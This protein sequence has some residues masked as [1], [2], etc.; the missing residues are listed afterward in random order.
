M[1]EN[2]KIL[3]LV[4]SYSIGVTINQVLAE[5]E[6]SIPDDNTGVEMSRQILVMK[7]YPETVNSAITLI[8]AAIGG[9]QKLSGLYEGCMDKYAKLS[10][11]SSQAP[12]EDEVQIK[13]TL[14]SVILKIE[15]FFETN[16][17]ADENIIK[18]L[19][20]FLNESNL[21]G[22]TDSEIN[23]MNIAPYTINNIIPSFEDLAS[24]IDSYHYYEEILQRLLNISTLILETG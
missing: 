24:L 10:S 9:R 21:H 1:S 14:S 22:K 13:S 20:T 5:L 8:A 17:R 4:R 11:L 3:D 18:N 23:Y 2:I 19:H 12:S 15:S 6:K 16:D 7:Q